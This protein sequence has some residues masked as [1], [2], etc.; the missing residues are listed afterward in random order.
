VTDA[1]VKCAAILSKDD[2]YLAHRQL[3]DANK[4]KQSTP[5]QRDGHGKPDILNFKKSSLKACRRTSLAHNTG[6]LAKTALSHELDSG[7]LSHEL[8]SENFSLEL[9][10][11]IL[12][13]EQELSYEQNSDDLSPKQNLSHKQN[14]DSHEQLLYKDT[15]S[16]TA[17]AATHEARDATSEQGK[18]A[19]N[20]KLN[21]HKTASVELKSVESRA[22]QKEGRGMEEAS[23]GLCNW[24]GGRQ[25]QMVHESGMVTR[26]ARCD[27]LVEP[28]TRSR[29]SGVFAAQ[30]TAHGDKEGP[31]L[32]PPLVVDPFERPMTGVFQVLPKNRMSP[33]NSQLSLQKSQLSLQKSHPTSFPSGKALGPNGSWSTRE[34]LAQGATRILARLFYAVFRVRLSKRK[35]VGTQMNLQINVQANVLKNVKKNVLETR[36]GEGGGGGQEGNLLEENGY[37]GVMAAARHASTAVLELR[38]R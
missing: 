30:D 37:G 22:T 9:N 26:E 10:S 18:L 2:Q 32:D 1:R 16:P 24:M 38:I 21:T 34:A 7:N 28:C 35:V 27:L 33:Q 31:T 14:S 8:D 12:S 25:L 4:Q 3:V 19:E 5:R 6:V 29:S 15:L 17:P 23:H 13:H 36:G 20:Q 11:E